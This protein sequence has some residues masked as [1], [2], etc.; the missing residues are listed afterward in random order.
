MKI[1]PLIELEGLF[2]SY[3]CASCF[4]SDRLCVLKTNAVFHFL[5]NVA[6]KM[7]NWFS[8]ELRYYL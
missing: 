4:I 8:E 5:L 6:I 3:F 2:T 1:M 7:G